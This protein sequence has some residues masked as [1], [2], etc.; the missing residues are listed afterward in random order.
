[1]A[2]TLPQRILHRIDRQFIHRT[3]S[4]S[5]FL[6]IIKLSKYCQMGDNFPAKFAKKHINEN[7]KREK[8]FPDSIDP[9][10]VCTSLSFS[11]SISFLHF[12]LSETDKTSHF[13]RVKIFRLNLRY[14][15]ILEKVLCENCEILDK[16]NLP[17]TPFLRYHG[18]NNH[19]VRFTSFPLQP[20]IL[21][22]TFHDIFIQI[23][24]I[25]LTISP[26]HSFSTL[27]VVLSTLTFIHTWCFFVG[28]VSVI[29]ILF[30]E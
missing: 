30:S 17:K 14:V 4:L 24:M 11:P 26:S 16:R 8:S 6:M 23:T 5:P 22:N 7:G 10:C 21:S 27:S 18:I 20:P 19:M 9:I 13:Y 1:M 28:H 12:A 25:F 29:C 15:A 3:L 2:R